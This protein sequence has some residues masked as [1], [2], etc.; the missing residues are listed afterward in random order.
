MVAGEA[1][2]K[3]GLPLSQ[4]AVAARQRPEVRRRPVVAEP[5]VRDEAATRLHRAVVVVVVAAAVGAPAVSI[6]PT[7]AAPVGAV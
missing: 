7:M 2:P 6:D 1:V 3:R 5:Q 4:P